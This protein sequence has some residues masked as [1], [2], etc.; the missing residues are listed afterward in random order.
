[1]S[2]VKKQKTT[3][4]LLPRCADCKLGEFEPGESL[5]DCHLFPMDWIQ[6]E[7]GLV[8]M[9]KPAHKDGY[10]RSFERKVH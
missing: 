8:A 5:G 4:D 1:M 7:A 2:C 10:C 9:C 6:T 3:S